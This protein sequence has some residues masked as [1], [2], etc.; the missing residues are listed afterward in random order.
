M[1]HNPLTYPAS[2]ER[3]WRNMLAS[4]TDYEPKTTFFSDLSIAE[5]FGANAIKETYKD[6]IQ[7]WGDDIVHIT[8][9]TMCLKH[10][11]W[12]LYKVDEP[13]AK[14]YDELWRKSCDYVL[15]HFKGEDLAYFY[16]V[17]D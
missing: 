3:W 5:C 14:L 17:T 6:V 12:Q 1:K 2:A 7:Q 8:E 11:I 9:F 4:M 15:N 13:I 16:K 10:K